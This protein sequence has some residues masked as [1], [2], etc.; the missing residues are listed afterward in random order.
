VT[1]AGL[2]GIALRSGS[3]TIGSVLFDMEMLE[4]LFIVVR[5]NEA[6]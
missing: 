4:F 3:C 5:D 1:R 2:L 6:I